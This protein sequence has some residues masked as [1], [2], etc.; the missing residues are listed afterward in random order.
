MFEIKHEVKDFTSTCHL[1]TSQLWQ[2]LY[3]NVWSIPSKKQIQKQENKNI[4]TKTLIQKQECK[5]KTQK[6]RATGCRSNTSSLMLNYH[7]VKSIQFASWEFAS[8]TP[9][10]KDSIKRKQLYISL[11]QFF[12]T[13]GKIHIVP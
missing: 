9:D 10:T 11:L 13:P 7:L 12:S 2:F 5:H 4:N 6:Y 1:S 3:W 8:I